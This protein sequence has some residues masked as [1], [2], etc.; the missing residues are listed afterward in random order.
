VKGE[1]NKVLYDAVIVG[2]GIAGLQAAIQLGRYEHRVLVI[3]KGYG[4]STLCKR[5]SN[6]LGWPDGV[7]GQELRDKGR[8]HAAKYGIEFIE[9]EIKQAKK[10]DEGNQFALQGNRGEYHGRMLLLATGVTDRLP[11]L[12]GLKACMGRSIFICPDC[13][14]YEAKG[15]RTLVLGAGAPGAQMALTLSYWTQDI[16]LINHEQKE[17]NQELTGKLQ[18]KNIQVY[19]QPIQLLEEHEG[20][21]QAV[22]LQDG[23][24]VEAK[25]AFTSFGGNQI[26]TE[27]A[28]Q[29]GVERLENQHAISDPRSKMSNVPGVWVAG[30][31]GV[32]SEQLTV[33]MAE[34]ALSA[35]WMHKHLMQQLPELQLTH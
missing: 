14:G 29:L 32:H 35:I 28:K 20:N 18:D 2:G 27:L 11:E 31:I 6:V 23:T 34:G 21:L 12:E 5:Y 3:D 4:R 19:H 25:I 8:Q 26:H 33:A 17:I 1:G 15:Q 22:M 16:I 13:D 30:D 9:D 10:D 7:S 24:R